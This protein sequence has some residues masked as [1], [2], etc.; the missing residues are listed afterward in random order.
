MRTY[1]AESISDATQPK[2]IIEDADHAKVLAIAQ[3]ISDA[4]QITFTVGEKT[5]D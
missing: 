5:D 1:I 3:L 2:I 4:T